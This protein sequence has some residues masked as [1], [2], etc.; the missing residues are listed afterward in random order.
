MKKRL[1]AV[2]IILILIFL[3]TKIKYYIED[4]KYLKRTISIIT[5]NQDSKDI[6]Y[7]LIEHIGKIKKIDK[8]N[9]Q[10][11]KI[12]VNG[13]YDD[14]ILKGIKLNLKKCVFINDKKEEIKINNDLKNIVTQVSKINHDIIGNK[15][16]VIDNLYFVEVELNVNMWS[17]YELYYYDIKNNKLIKY[18]TFDNIDIVGI[19]I[20]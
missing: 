15:I 9:N 12:T 3:Y 16:F 8:F 7:Y 14:Y 4:S 11:Q 10:S 2:I 5:E 17:P 13:C 6:N 1:L 18:Y 20:N 19:K